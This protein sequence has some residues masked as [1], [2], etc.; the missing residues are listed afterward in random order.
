MSMEHHVTAMCKAGFYHLRNISRIRK[1]IRYKTL[2]CT[3]RATALFIKCYFF[4]GFLVEVAVVDLKGLLT[5]FLGCVAKD[6]II[7]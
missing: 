2:K 3:S 7:N 4:S 5:Y 6:V 1:F